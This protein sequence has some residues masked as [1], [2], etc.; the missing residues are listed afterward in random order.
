LI[1]YPQTNE[2][3]TFYAGYIQRVPQ[4]SDIFKLLSQQIGE[5]GLLLQHTTDEAASERPA[6]EEW[7]IKEVMGHI[8]DS[9]RIFAYRAL[10]FARAD[11]KELQG[12]EQDDYVKATDFNKRSLAGLLEE[13]SLQRRSNIL[14]FQALSEEESLRRGVASNNPITVRALLFILAGHVMHHIE[15]LQTSYKLGAK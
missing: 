15:S 3:A 8:C 5:L 1:S 7:S 13:F 4:N 2:Y 12:Y 14:C 10:R 11:T 6:P 9:E